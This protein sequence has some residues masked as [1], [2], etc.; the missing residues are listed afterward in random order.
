MKPPRFSYARPDSVDDALALLAENPDEVR[1]MAGGQSLGA[2]LN[3]RLAK[4][5]CV[6]DISALAELSAITLRD[7]VLE[8]G[9]A[10]TQG[11]LLSWPGLAAQ[12]PLLALAMPHIGHFQTRNKGT[13]CGSIAHADPAS[14][15]PLCLAVLEGQVVLRSRKGSRTL[16]AAQFQTG[17]LQT[18]RRADELITS[19][20]FPV[21]PLGQGAAFH[22][23]AFR[24][25]DFAVVATAALTV[26][27]NRVRLGVA[28]V[29]DRPAV[30][31]LQT[32][33][34]AALDHALNALAWSLGAVDDAHADAR[35]RR[36]LV[37]RQGL[38]TLKE[39]LSCAS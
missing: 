7:G 27:P 26:G 21:A 33:D 12:V 9:A 20:R 17:M 6:L 3:M 34:E 18:A 37:R 15:L 31:T 16:S 38:T 28:G 39:A 13:V 1:V 29:A 35:Y 32:D 5:A 22:E 36:T 2:V 19:V 25:G 14:E 8:V 4:P 23:T 30:V 10:V 11:T 24:H